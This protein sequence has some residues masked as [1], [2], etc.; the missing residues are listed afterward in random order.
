MLRSMA[1][2]TT[3]WD[4]TPPE[5]GSAREE[6][7]KS[8]LWLP[9]LEKGSSYFRFDNSRTSALSIIETFMTKIKGTLQIQHEIIDQHKKLNDTAAGQVLNAVLNQSELRIEHKLDSLKDLARED[10]RPAGLDWA[11]EKSRIELE[12]QIAAVQ[13]SRATLNVDIA[14]RLAADE[15]RFQASWSH[16]L[17]LLKR[18]IEVEQSEQYPQQY[19]MALAAQFPGI[20]T[21]VSGCIVM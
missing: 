14:Q 17:E 5:D 2:V 12:A 15:E 7:L 16:Q 21:G 13:A 8:E 4:L 9:F 1:I 6:E 20:A 19:S 11:P 3:M 18:K 10:M